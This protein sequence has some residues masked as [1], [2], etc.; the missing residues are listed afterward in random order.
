MQCNSLLSWKLSSNAEPV[1][2]SASL[3][4][5]L[6][7]LISKWTF[8]CKSYHTALK[9]NEIVLLVLLNPIPW[10]YSNEHYEKSNCPCSFEIRVHCTVKTTPSQSKETFYW[11]WF[12]RIMSYSL[13]FWHQNINIWPHLH[14]NDTYSA[15]IWLASYRQKN[16][17]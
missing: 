11:K 1:C 7:E 5:T 13:N 17:T 16:D 3:S 14:I 4:Q 12:A 15:R 6:S 8:R 10:N 9:N 2:V